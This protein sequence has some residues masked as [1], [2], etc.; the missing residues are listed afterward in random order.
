M[1]FSFSQRSIARMDGVHPDIIAVMELA[2][3]RSSI[4]FTVLEGV[5]SADRQREMVRIGASKTLNS[6]HLTGHAIDIAP[7]VDGDVSWDWPVYHKLAPIIKGAAEDLGVD[8]E[9]GGDWK[10]FKDGPHWQ[11]SWNTYSKTD[12]VA[13]ATLDKEMSQEVATVGRRLA[14]PEEVAGALN[15]ADKPP[16]KSTTN[17]AAVIGIVQAGWVAF[18]SADPIV[19]ASALIAGAVLA[20]ILKERIRKAK[21]GK[22]AKEALGL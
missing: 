13:R 16:A 6:R 18:Q 3:A 11:L 14:L 1:A 9:W 8:L 10:S 5:R 20:Y 2:L 12:M 17:W 7:L 21:L 4:D 19:Q 15:D 22:V